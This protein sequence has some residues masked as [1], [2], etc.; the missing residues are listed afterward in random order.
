MR[1]SDLG[2]SR[3]RRTLLRKH[4]SKD[5]VSDGRR[6]KARI[7]KLVERKGKGAKAIGDN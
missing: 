6:P 5:G 4:M 7:Q 1:T 2:G 3:A